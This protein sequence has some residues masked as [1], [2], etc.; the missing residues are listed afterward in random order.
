M[1]TEKDSFG[2]SNVPD[3]AYYG[4][5]TARASRLNVSNTL[6]FPNEFIYS[7]ALL[8]KASALSNLKLKKIDSH[9]ANAIAEACDEVR[10]GK[11]NGDFLIGAIQAGAGTSMNMNLNEVICN[12]A[13][14]LMGKKKGD[15]VTI[16]PNDHV[17]LSQSTND[18]FPSAVHVTASIILFRHLLPALE[19]LE[20]AF[21]KKAAEFQGIVKSGRTHGQ[22]AVPLFLG[23]EFSGYAGI[24]SKNREAIKNS[25]EGLLELCI[26]GS[27]VGTGI[28]S[29]RLFGSEVVSLLNKETGL[30]FSLSENYFA[31]MQNITAISHASSSLK[32]FALALSKIACDLK[33][34]SSS[35][36][37]EVS[38][39]AI[40]PGSSIMPGK[41]N[42]S[43]PELTQ[44]SCYRVA[45]ND[46]TVSFCQQAGSLEL[47][48]M[49]PIAGYCLLESMEILEKTSVLMAECVSGIIPNSEKI[50]FHLDE[51][52]I[53][54]TALNEKIGYDKVSELVKKVGK[55][56]SL[57][58]VLKEE[59]L[60]MPDVN[61]LAKP[62]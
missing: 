57:G 35:D 31:S 27:A 2:E 36:V 53:V 9:R 41:V 5:F 44:M 49:M 22:Y 3:E 18:T 16:H 7:Y 13:L 52:P 58:Q 55:G 12:R 48:V 51:N 25:G 42:P 21:R 11:Y 20:D 56:K 17:N 29:G 23:D 33:V 37:G 26:G 1:R 30:G 10:R 34:L 59:N 39:R 62:N 15:Y 6:F 8:K 38:L 4:P 60:E 61:K 24:I 46:C 45:G 50:A 47:N 43:I 19:K 54:L 28:N 32:D 14:E 40:Q